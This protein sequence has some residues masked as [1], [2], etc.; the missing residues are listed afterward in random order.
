MNKSIQAMEEVRRQVQLTATNILSLA[1][2]AAAIGDIINTV[3]GI[4]EQ[5]NLLSLNAAVEASRAGEHGKG[6]AVVANE[7]KE[8]AAQSK[9]ATGE[10]GLILNGPNNGF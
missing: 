4:A 9:K 1:E 6:F 7:V 2:R 8:L 3:K 5:T 10:I